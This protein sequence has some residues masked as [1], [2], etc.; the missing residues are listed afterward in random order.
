[1]QQYQSII[2]RRALEALL[3]RETGLTYSPLHKFMKLN[4]VTKGQPVPGTGGLRLYSSVVV[5]EVSAI[6]AVAHRSDE[7]RMAVGVRA[8]AERL[9]DLTN[10][11]QERLELLEAELGGLNHEM[12]F[13][14]FSRWKMFVIAT[15]DLSACFPIVDDPHLRAID[16]AAHRLSLQRRVNEMTHDLDL[17]VAG[18]SDFRLG[19]AAQRV[20]AVLQAQL[21]DYA[22]K[23][24]QLESEEIVLPTGNLRDDL[25]RVLTELHFSLL[26]L[27]YAEVLA[28]EGHQGIE[29][30]NNGRDNGLDIRSNFTGAGCGVQCKCRTATVGRPTL[31]A[32][33]GRLVSENRKYGV[34]VT[35]GPVSRPLL[36]TADEINGKA[37]NDPSGVRIEIVD[38]DALV[39]KLLR[40]SVGIDASGRLDKEFWKRLEAGALGHS[41]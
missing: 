37:E 40:Y 36:I 32:L 35:T 5:A 16:T 15:T 8:L 38:G 3:A 9:H 26:P 18:A 11:R 21:E 28:R 27:L 33:Y 19:S 10:L 34:L 41:A 12:S 22:T 31:D 7:N 30:A 1:M 13:K 6:R 39:D 2:G 4:A 20:S 25:K 17:L 24:S 29:V 23:L 14:L